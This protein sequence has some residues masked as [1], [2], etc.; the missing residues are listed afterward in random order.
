MA[1]M[2]PRWRA[3]KLS[4]RARRIHGHS[5]AVRRAAWPDV[6]YRA[7]AGL[8]PASIFSAASSPAA[9]ARY[10]RPSHT[11]RIDASADRPDLRALPRLRLRR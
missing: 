4:S 3:A 7:S 1:L 9:R 10:P 2:Y 6:P 8:S 5:D 11:S